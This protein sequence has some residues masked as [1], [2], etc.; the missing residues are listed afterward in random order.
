VESEH[1]IG[2]RQHKADVA[3]RLHLIANELVRD[4][5]M[6]E[7]LY[8]RAEVHDDSKF[9]PEEMGP[10]E[11]E[12]PNLKNLVYGTPEYQASLDRLKP[13]LDHHYAANDHHPQYHVNG[14][15]DM[16]TVQRI[17]MACDWDASVSRQK[18]GDIYKGLEI[19]RKRFSLT[20]EQ[21]D[22]LKG[23]IDFL[24]QGGF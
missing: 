1:V 7:E 20:D 16:N 2:V 5:S 14:V 22:E 19:N 10:F 12:T 13:A 15:N 6:R 18:S 3:A 24:K 8:H 17:E 9:S 11:R 4:Q 21:F 23:Y